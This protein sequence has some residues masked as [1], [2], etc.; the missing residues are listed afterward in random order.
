M[1]LGDTDM[2]HIMFMKQLTVTITPKLLSKFKA[3]P[4]SFGQTKKTF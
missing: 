2:Y 4:A 1:G 3:I